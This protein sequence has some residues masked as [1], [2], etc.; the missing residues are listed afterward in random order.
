MRKL[1]DQAGQE[2]SLDP[3]GY[4]AM[5]K[6]REPFVEIDNANVTFLHIAAVVITKSGN[7]A[8]DT[9]DVYQRQV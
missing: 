3:E 5:R 8:A 2:R 6:F 1:W 9:G 7:E 4:A